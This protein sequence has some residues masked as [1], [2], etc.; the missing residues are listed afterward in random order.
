MK[1]VSSFL[2][3]NLLITGLTFKAAGQSAGENRVP[4]N[5]INDLAAAIGK[6]YAPDRRTAI[7]Q[8]LRDSA[9]NQYLQTTEI[10]AGQKFSDTLIR[11]GVSISVPIKTL[12]SAEL[13]EKKSALVN[14][15][16]ANFRSEPR[17]AAE[18]AT[19]A[20]LGTPL[21]ILKKEGYYYLVRTPDK[22]IAWLDAGALSIKTDL[23]LKMWK[24]TR[25][26]VFIADY[27]HAYQKPQI[28]SQRVSDLVMGDILIHSGTEKGFVKVIY[29]DGKEAY[30]KQNLVTDFAHWSSKPAP[31]ADEVI[32]I[33]KTMIGVPYLWGG[34]SVKG[35]DCSGFTKTAFF[36]N[37][38]V[39]PR[40]A[41]QQVLAGTSVP[42][43][44][45]DTLNLTEALK[46]L[47]PGDLIFFAGGNKRKSDARVT[48]VAMY[49]G[50]GEFIHSSGQVRINS[51]KP[52]TANYEDFET[53]TVVAARRY[54][55]HTGSEGI[56]PV[57]K[58]PA[59]VQK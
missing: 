34:T 19:Q 58:H 36:M 26:I 39:I 9:G 52:G 29:P 57:S 13:G 25:K 30:I 16:V 12:P 45:S 44:K 54:I 10:N 49:L 42:V 20:L 4:V 48:H 2:L 5:K 38:I 32:G 8:I 59:Y 51:M 23:E 46:N 53:R 33:A 50:D 14:V 24:Q 18:L 3:L 28:N 11:E 6:K 7:F 21:D 35:V 22:Y 1:I 17:N 15:S 55:G 40:D 27:G 43:L 47:K 41:S 37:G 31:A 56:V